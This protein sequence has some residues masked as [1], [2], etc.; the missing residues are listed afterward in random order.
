MNRWVFLLG[1]GLVLRAAIA[2]WLPPGFDEAYYFAYSLNPRLSYFDHPPLVAFTTGL[3]PWLTGEVSQFTI[4]LG[5]LLLYT[6]SLY[7]LYL[8]SQK[9]FSNKVATL[10]LAIA[11]VIPFFQVGF[12]VLTLPD[13]PLLFFWSASL[14]L[15][16]NEF[17]AHS[18][19]Y[20]PSY[21]LVGLGLLLGLTCLGKYHGFI[22]GLGLVAFCLTSSNH[23]S[24]LKSP[25]TALAVVLFLSALTPVW[26]WNIQHDWVSFRFQA[27]RAIPEA[28]YNPERLLGTFLVGIGCLFPTFGFPLWWVS[29]RTAFWRIV[30]SGFAKKNHNY[31]AHQSL[32]QQKQSLILWVSLPLILGF[33]LLGGY[34]P[35]LPSWHM[36]GFWGATLLLGAWV[37]QV[38]EKTPQR[39]HYWLWGSGVSIVLLFTVVLLHVNTGLL[40]KDG[41]QAL[42]GGWV[43]VQS[44]A[45]IQ[46]TDIQQLRQGFAQSPQ[47]SAELAKADFVFTNRFFLSGYVAMALA[48]LFTKPITCFDVDPRGFAYWSQA[49]QW[50]G[51]SALYVTSELYEGNLESL[52]RYQDYFAAMTH[53]GRIT[54]RRGGADIQV[55]NIYRC[56]QQLR[57]YPWPY[58]A[59]ANL[60]S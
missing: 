37:A 4:R 1:W 32:I 20:R 53:L 31:S 49:Q 7:L 30:P 50:L 5:T 47:F 24:A 60:N 51:K 48:P 59:T 43:P 58:G 41:D 6:A 46:L 56:E 27:T 36:P 33:T 23:R 15:A 16:V 21:R 52:S 57:P 9:L 22:L 42:L 14:Y 8:T 44:D 29:L 38:Q 11:T 12:G 18:A 28:A 55:F 40:Q 13:T 19:I 17:F 10:T 45:S 34:R 2:A 39:V 25:W 54:I 26:L 35:V 3:G